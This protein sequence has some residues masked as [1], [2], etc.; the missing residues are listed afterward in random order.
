MTKMIEYIWPAM[1]VYCVL[2][3]LYRKTT[4]KNLK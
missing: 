1:T 2:L 4:R 3:C